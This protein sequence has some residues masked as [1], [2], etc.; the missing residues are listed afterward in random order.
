VHCS[1]LQHSNIKHRFTVP[2]GNGLFNTNFRNKGLN[3]DN[4]EAKD[5]IKI[6]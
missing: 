4:F 5:P 6:S 3:W 1:I 2:D